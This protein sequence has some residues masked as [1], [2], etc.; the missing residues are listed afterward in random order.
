MPYIYS[1]HGLSIRWE[2]ETY[3]TQDGEIARDVFIAPPEQPREQ[4]ALLMPVLAPLV[5]TRLAAIEV[6]LEQFLTIATSIT[7]ATTHR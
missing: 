3:V 2:D 5:E 7:T 4:S 1:N 6:R